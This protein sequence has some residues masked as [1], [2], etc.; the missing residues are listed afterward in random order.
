[1]A[2]YK[3][4]CIEHDVEFISKGG[5]S[6]CP[7]C[8]PNGP[9]KEAGGPEPAAESGP[10][11]SSHPLT[12]S[13]QRRDSQFAPA[14]RQP[15]VSVP[16]ELK[17]ERWS[18]HYSTP[19]EWGVCAKCGQRDQWCHVHNRIHCGCEEIDMIKLPK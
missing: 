5:K 12:D 19:P 16:Y 8:F 7:Q 1:M 9:E 18:C 11:G 2:M 17:Y 14:P 4:K 6:Y 15:G 13:E 10:E 3:A